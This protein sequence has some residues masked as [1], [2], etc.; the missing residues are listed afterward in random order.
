MDVRDAVATRF[1]CRAFLPTPV[2]LAIV[3]DI[4]DRAAR[5]PSG[6]NLQPWRVHALAGAP[7]EKLKAMIRPL[8]PAN[9]RGEGA[10]YAIYPDPLK[11]PYRARR[12]EV[13]ALLYRAAGIA[14]QDRAARY[15][16]Y[17]RNFAFFDAPAGLFFSLDRS[18]GPPQWSDLG[19]FVQT[20]MLL[21]RSHGLHSCGIEAWTHWHST[22]SLFL[23]LPATHILFCGMALGHADLAAPV[24]GW[25]APRAGVDDFAA[26]L[27][28][29]DPPERDPGV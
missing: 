12:F 27:G 18:M 21:A 1:S 26:F 2:P 25:R 13:G 11:E 8:A 16:Q 19:M 20:V 5:A 7:L 15:R 22:V 29:S 17:A 3:R 10:E 24:N 4:L 6:G 28:F 14:H 9:P 23:G